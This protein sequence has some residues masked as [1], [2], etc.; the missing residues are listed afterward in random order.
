MYNLPTQRDNNFFPLFPDYDQLTDG[1]KRMNRHALMRGWFDENDPT[2]IIANFTVFLLAFQFYVDFYIKRA[3]FLKRY[4][5]RKHDWTEKYKMVRML[6]QRRSLV[7]AP[8]ECGKTFT[9]IFELTPFLAQFRP[10]TEILIG[11]ENWQMTSEK[12]ET[13]RKRIERNELIEA[14]FGAIWP[15]KRN[16]GLR[17]N[18]SCLDLVNGSRIHGSSVDAATRGRHPQIGILDD[19]EGKKSK[20]SP[21]WRKQFMSWLRSDYIPQFD[22]HH[23]ILLWVGSLFHK[24]CC[25]YQAMHEDDPEMIFSNWSKRVF[26]MVYEDPD[27]GRLV[28]S[29]PEKLTVEQFE[30]KKRG[31]ADGE[32]DVS[33]I[34]LAA[35]MAEFQG[36]PMAGGEHMFQRDPRMN[37]YLV[38]MDETGTMMKYDPVKRESVPYDEWVEGLYVYM[39]VD[40][41]DSEDRHADYSGIV[42][43]GVDD[44]RNIFV[45]DAWHGRVWSEKTTRRAFDYCDRWKV[46]N[47]GWDVTALARRIFREAVKLR[48]EY[49]DKGAHV[50]RFIPVT[51]GG[52]P[53]ENRIERMQPD[54]IRG[55]IKLPVLGT[56]DGLTP[57]HPYRRPSI[58]ELIDEV[59][60]MTSEGTGGA[61]DLVDAMEIAYS[62]I[63]RAPS[64]KEYQHPDW[65]Q[66][67]KFRDVLGIQFPIGQLLPHSLPPEMAKEAEVAVSQEIDWEGNA[68]E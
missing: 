7:V 52:I 4:Y 28:S 60:T 8:R 44:E 39:G 54:W 30:A 12:I 33:V 36:E 31:T 13:T 14:D 49:K 26:K 25:L 17:W 11:G 22:D 56:L 65:A 38:H 57:T 58:R 51:T 43:L 41:A 20:R 34:G 18:N 64:K 46:A 48:T 10:Q 24:Q 37:S 59:E 5:Y 50:A 62:V 29:W 27:T 6:K 15:K 23:A 40:L 67:R 1:G 66:V 3:H 47:C 19:P 16:L 42:V 63:S 35:V 9:L 68:Y 21:V 45:L 55:K 32:T 2:T 61:D 53:K